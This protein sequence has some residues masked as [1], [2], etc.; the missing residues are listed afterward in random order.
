VPHVCLHVAG[1]ISWKLDVLFRTYQYSVEL[2]TTFVQEFIPKDEK[3]RCLDLLRLTV[4][5]VQKHP[6]THLLILPTF[7]SHTPSLLKQ[8]K[9]PKETFQDISSHS[10]DTGSSNNSLEPSCQWLPIF[11]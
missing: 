9:R 4:A 10:T 11:V 8:I 5:E 1:R 7:S 2:Q 3:Q 6:S